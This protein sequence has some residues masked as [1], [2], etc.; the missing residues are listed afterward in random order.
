MLETI[1]ING[2][3]RAPPASGDEGG[4]ANGGDDMAAATATKRPR[5]PKTRLR[6]ASPMWPQH[7]QERAER[8]F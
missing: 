1:G 6:A 3:F 4:G 7:C 5:T 8:L 2:P